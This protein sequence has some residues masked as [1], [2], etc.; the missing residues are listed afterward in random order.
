[1]TFIPCIL[2]SASNAPKQSHCQTGKSLAVCKKPQRKPVCDFLLVINSNWH[3]I[4][5]RFESIAAYCSNFGHC[6]FSPLWRGLRDNVRL[7]SWAH[8]KARSGLHVSVNWTFSLGVTAEALR[9]KIDRKS[10]ISLQRGQFDPKFQVKWV[11]P[12][13]IFTRIVWG[14]ELRDNVRLSSWAHWKACS[15]LPVSVNWTFSLGVTAEVL[16]ANIDRKSVISLQSG[17]FN[18]KFQVE[19]VAPINCF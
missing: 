19:W 12:S 3:P 15:G 10:V 14:W 5:Y 16:R 2:A 18:P 4:S 13:I 8:W 1:M 17:Q 11:A 6:V 9:A 7:S